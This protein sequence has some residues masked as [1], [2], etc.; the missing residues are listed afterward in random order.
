MRPR[1]VLLLHTAFI[2]DI[3][4]ALPLVQSL[5]RAA[6]EAEITFLAVP[7]AA[8]ALENHPDIAR[9]LRYDKRGADRGPAGLA[10]VIRTVR[11]GRFDLALVPH[12]SLRSALIPFLAGIPRRIGFDASAGR[13]LLSDRVPYRPGAHE[14]E[15]NI[16]LLR[17]LGLAPPGLDPSGTQ[18]GPGPEA[19]VL[20]RVY[21]NALDESVVLEWMKEAGLAG[22]VRPI[23]VAPGSIWN[24]KR[25]PADRYAALCRSLREKGEPVVLLGGAGD[26]ALCA[27]IAGIAGCLNVAGQL[28]LLQSA[29]LLR[30]CRLLVTNDTAPQHLA[31][32]VGTP[33]VAIFGPTVTGFGF[34]PIGPHDAV[35][36]TPDL[37]C[38]PCA[39]HGGDRCPIGTFE[40]MKLVSVERVLAAADRIIERT[41]GMTDG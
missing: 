11:A 40:C 8:G 20:P 13:W 19:P 31:V 34:A 5:R 28:S 4:L 10:R 16:D 41:A 30:R 14:T 33:V 1:K 17:P 7:S 21:P 32:A 9:I 35:V 22:N 36:E 24:T 15:R 37:A 29:A 25:W 12:R 6:P 27:S 2:G 38:R 23:A 39:I 3:I 26:A 18:W